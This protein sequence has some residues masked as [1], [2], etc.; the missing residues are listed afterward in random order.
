LLFQTLRQKQNIA[1]STKK[2]IVKSEGGS[3]RLFK[4]E[5]GVLPL[6]EASAGAASWS[7]HL[8]LSQVAQLQR[9]GDPPDAGGIDE[10]Q[11]QRRSHDEPE[12]AGRRGREE[13]SC[14]EVAMQPPRPCMHGRGKFFNVFKFLL[15]IY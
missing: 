2:F 13:E 15:T 5:C 4:Y 1:F 7:M 8:L 14:E 6:P 11:S 3:L 12:T 9:A 10:T